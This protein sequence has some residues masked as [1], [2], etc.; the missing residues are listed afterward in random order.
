MLFEGES[1]K[2][3]MKFQTW[4]DG[5]GWNVIKL[6]LFIFTL[7]WFEN[8]K[9]SV[10][11]QRKNQSI[12]PLVW[13]N[14]ETFHACKNGISVLLSE[15]LQMMQCIKRTKVSWVQRL[16]LM[17]T[18]SIDDYCDTLQTCSLSRSSDKWTWGVRCAPLA[19]F[20]VASH[21]QVTRSLP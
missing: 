9:F 13:Q 15:T 21:E 14:S 17:I 11:L 16:S 8:R 6:N 18:I 12:L 3:I 19:C 7:E 10:Y 4:D 20:F 1:V 2:I 5:P